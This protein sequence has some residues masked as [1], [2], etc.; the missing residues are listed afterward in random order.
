MILVHPIEGGH[1]VLRHM[2]PGSDVSPDDAA[3]KAQAWA[4]MN[5]P[6]KGARLHAA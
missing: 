2:C 1:D 4:E 6:P 3:A 5:Y